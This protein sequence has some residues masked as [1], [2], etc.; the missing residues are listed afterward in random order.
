MEDTDKSKNDISPRREKLTLDN[1]F[2]VVQL[3]IEFSKNGKEI[4]RLAEEDKKSNL[5]KIVKLVKKMVPAAIVSKLMK[6]NNAL[7]R[8]RQNSLQEFLYITEKLKHRVTNVKEQDSRMA[9]DIKAC[10]QE[11]HMILAAVILYEAHTII[12]Y[13][14][15]DTSAISKPNLVRLLLDV[16]SYCE[17]VNTMKF[18]VEWEN[19]ITSDDRST[20]KTT[21]TMNPDTKKE[22]SHKKQSLKAGEANSDDIARKKSGESDSDK[23]DSDKENSDEEETHTVQ[24][25]IR[26]NTGGFVGSTIEFDLVVTYEDGSPVKVHASDFA[27]EINGPAAS[28]PVTITT[29][30]DSSFR[31]EFIPS[32]PG[33]NTLSIYMHNT[34]LTSGI[35]S[36]IS[37]AGETAFLVHSKDI[38][39]GQL[40]GISVVPTSANKGLTKS[41]LLKQKLED[42]ATALELLEH[43]RTK[44]LAE[45]EN[46]SSTTT[47]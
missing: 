42:I 35:K 36:I 22:S 27:V 30:N 16:K 6:P 17:S 43:L 24:I 47:T 34:L 10:V 19:L 7:D 13:Y 39:R 4:I 15:S 11:G 28:S 37:K 20:K 18:P 3:A 9:E 23:E 32:E 31:I 46:I 38:S 2:K 44:T 25:E 21:I 40:Q 45:I 5:Q 29:K 14:S 8:R 33:A 41:E 12:S 1:S 26:G